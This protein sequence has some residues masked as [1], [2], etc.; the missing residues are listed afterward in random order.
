MPMGYIPSKDEVVL[1]QLDGD[2]TKEEVEKAKKYAIEGC[3][4]VYELQ[5]GALK[6]KFKKE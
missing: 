6:D 5:K 4:K 2:F 3:K 1:L